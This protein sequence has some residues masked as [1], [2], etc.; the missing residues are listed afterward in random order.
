MV[1]EEA[2]SPFSTAVR[3]SPLLATFRGTE[4]LRYN[5]TTDP[6]EY[7]GCFTTE[8]ELHQV[9]DLTKC[10]LLASTLRGNAHYWF[11]K[12]GPR[13][14]GSWEQM[15]RMFLTQFQSSIHYAPPVTTLANIRQK[16]EE[17]LQAYFQ[18]FNAKVP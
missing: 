17:T 8:M 13:S 11:Q 15:C 5:G 3:H 18:R 12:I 6:V 14:I 7:I 1:P 4:D 2:V 9:S 16:E 10:R